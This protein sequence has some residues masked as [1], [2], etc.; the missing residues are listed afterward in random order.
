MENN[1]VEQN[2]SI[3]TT[4][5]TCE[6]VFV[7]KFFRYRSTCKIL[8]KI[9]LDTCRNQR[10]E[11]RTKLILPERLLILWNLSQDEWLLFFRLEKQK[12]LKLFFIFFSNSNPAIRSSGCRE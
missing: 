8:R 11:N 1:F 3:S 2:P 9:T 7:V 6:C 10:I 5:T 12:S 4:N